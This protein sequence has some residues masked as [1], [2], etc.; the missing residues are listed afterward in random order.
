M[1]EVKNATMLCGLLNKVTS[2][3]GGL[4][5]SLYYHLSPSVAA[6][7]TT[8]AGKLVLA[9]TAIRA[10]IPQMIG[11]ASEAIA[12]YN[13]PVVDATGSAGKYVVGKGLKGV[14]KVVAGEA[15]VPEVMQQSYEFVKGTIYNKASGAVSGISKSVQE[16]G[17]KGVNEATNFVNQTMSD[18]S[19]GIKV[20][21]EGVGDKAVGMMDRG[22]EMVQTNVDKLA[23]MGNGFKDQAYT[24]AKEGVDILQNNATHYIKQGGVAA[25]KGMDSG[26]KMI[27]DN[28]GLLRDKA[29]DFAKENPTIAVVGGAA[30][31]AAVGYL[32]YTAYNE[33]VAKNE[34]KIE[35]DKKSMAAK[36]SKEFT[37]LKNSRIKT[38]N[39]EKANIANKFQELQTFLKDTNDLSMIRFSQNMVYKYQ[40]DQTIDPEDVKKLQEMAVDK[41][42]GANIPADKMA[43]LQE[44]SAELMASVM[45]C[46]QITKDLE[47]GRVSP[48]FVSKVA[49]ERAGKTQRSRSE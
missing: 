22:I 14:A 45:M 16:Q 20:V 27:Q 42:Q 24:A 38:M 11:K 47:R 7:E 44:T 33:Y 41:V 6:L 13:N 40:K 46:D 48:S 1:P 17:V 35:D 49:A 18:I 34:Q 23:E 12:P 2:Q 21:Q 43:K 8:A 32:S 28:A 29:I 10:G 31:L 15:T 5:D 39:A 26:I 36:V 25:S 9:S 30:A 4:G 37:Q 3:M 19:D